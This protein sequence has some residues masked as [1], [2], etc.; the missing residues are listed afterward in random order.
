MKSSAHFMIIVKDV[1][2]STLRR[3]RYM[4]KLI[5]LR[6][7]PGSGKS[8]FI[9]E[10]NLDMF[11]LSTDQIRLMFSSPEMTSNY[12][13]DIPQ[14]NNKK[15]WS[16]L[17]FLLEER[18]K[19]GEFTIIDAVHAS[20]KENF[21]NYKKLA[22][23]YRYRLYVLD[24]TGIPK[25][26]V[27]KRNEGREEYKQVSSYVIDRAYKLFAKEKVSS[28]FKIVSPENFG[29]IINNNPRDFNCYNNIHIFGD[30]HGCCS[31][32]KQY[33]EENPIQ[34]HDAYIFTG[35]YFDRGLENYQTFTYLIELM[36][37][38][39]M[40]FLVGNHEDKLYK[41]ACNDEFKM[42]YDIK[43]TIT[44]LNSNNISK[45]E[46]RGFI[47]L[48]S[49]ICFFKFNNQTYLITHGGI[50]YIPKKSLDF[51]S[52]NSFVYG[53]DK[54]DTNID[55]IYNNYMKEQ[56]DQIIQIH[57]HRN[58]F[59]IQYNEYEYSINLDG[60]IEHGGHLRV[61]T[62]S[63]NGDRKCIEIKNNIYNPNLIEETNIYNLVHELRDNRYIIEKEL[64]N[65]IS[66]FN[67]TREAFHYHLWDH[68]TTQARGL[69]IN[70][71][72]YKIVAR[73]YNKFFNINERKDTSLEELEKKL[74]YPINFY[75]KYNG[76]LGILS[77]NEGELFFA[78]KSTDT[79]N[80]VEYFK[81]IFYK[82]YSEK[83]IAVL[84]AKM[85]Q[86]NITI[87]F[88]VI[89]PVNDPHIIEYKEQNIIILDMIHNTSNYS[90]IPYDELKRFADDYTFEMKE[91]IY[92]ASSLEEFKD[93]YANIISSDY[94]LNGKYIEG[95]V[96]EDNNHFMVKMKTNYYNTWKYLR[97]KMEYA[98]KKHN[99][100]S[101]T[102]KNQLEEMFMRY[103]KVKYENK[104]YDIQQINIID[105]RNNFEKNRMN[106]NI[107]T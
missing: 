103:L 102:C 19:K 85:L 41:Y 96:I 12:T 101:S 52:T 71:E 48:L 97:T 37:H 60:N 91:L 35:D 76:F 69:F 62:L 28:P 105:E 31:T 74:V 47:K 81:D 84:K 36:K 15:V 90:K 27:Y 1:I 13:E 72:K 5:I 9:K 22:E 14:F 65:N 80:Y 79:G 75:L 2:I 40:I 25:E 100:N 18:M 11:T 67:F 73:S 3:Y 17:Y 45:K 23:K 54:Y 58:Y 83:Q 21:P 50:P 95:Y 107:Y 4:R 24:F 78:S 55:E 26:E 10:N 29:E 57:G 77:L 92:T 30:I 7:A 104:D 59:K 53:I 49:Q 93:I 38:D 34:D 33:F 86:E 46:I 66:S 98:L 87:V 51:Y 6:G 64:S 44:E 16:L 89:D 82:K 63:K 8:T 70:T 39:N 32:L 56:R 20:I 88:E 94:Q 42:D 61:L 106:D 68:M 99:F 43:N